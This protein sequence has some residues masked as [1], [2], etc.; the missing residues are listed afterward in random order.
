MVS[1]CH[2]ESGDAA[3]CFDTVQLDGSCH[4]HP[5]TR[6][7]LPAFPHSRFHFINDSFSLHLFL[8]PSSALLSG[9]SEVSTFVKLAV[10]DGVMY[11]LFATAEH[12]QT[13]GKHAS[14]DM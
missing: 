5:I 2:P 7:H 11:K 4:S 10:G 8:F 6:Y 9:Y 12:L 1:Q 14:L 13:D 3:G